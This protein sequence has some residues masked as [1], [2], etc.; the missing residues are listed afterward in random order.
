MLIGNE[1]VGADEHIESVSPFSEEVV[2][3]VPRGTVAHVDRAARAASAAYPEWSRMAP[4]SRAKLLRECAAILRE[5]AHELGTL[6]A[7]DCGNPAGAMR[8]DVDKAASGLEYN[9]GLAGEAK[10][11]TVPTAA[12]LLD[13]TINEP[14]GVVARIIP[15]N[16]PAFFLAGKMAAP[17][18]AGNCVIMKPS[19]YTSLSAAR[20][21][22][23][24]KDVFPPGVVNIVTG[25]G[26][27]VGQAIVEHPDIPRIAFIGSVATGRR[28]YTSAAERIKTVT[29]ELGGKNALIACE[30]ANPVDVGRAAAKGMN[31]AV[32]AGQ[33]CGA[34]SRLIVHD[35]IHDA[36]V[37]ALIDALKKV[38]PGDPLGA[39]TTMGPLTHKLQ[40]DKALSY[41]EK[42][43]A[44][45]ATLALGGGRPEHLPM[46]YF[47]SPTVFTDV[48]VDMAI[49][50]EEIFS[51][52]ISVLRFSD[53]DEGIRIAND[54][55]YGLA[56]S[57]FTN[58][59]STAYT[60]ARELQSGYVWVNS[61]GDRPTGAPFGGYKQSGIGRES[62]LDELMSYTRVKNVCTRLT[63]G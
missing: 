13:F 40:Y 58:D 6:D 33:S 38:H 57:I 16:H 60:A 39:D 15:F 1:L 48:T 11:V 61:T 9:A 28:I 25:Y 41:I 14:F 26:A 23:L 12:S 27:D 46:G 49:A 50:R 52:V 7:L 8:A 31:L 47:L 56:S 34:I 42:A 43:R 3:T 20:I 17:L 53:V 44:D 18:A 21:G 4:Q 5:N 45:G 32:T 30:D 36:T 55:E 24:I 51:P 19:E 59:I 22:E 37:S 63:A 29:L 10:G 2:G 54:T 35:S 62:S